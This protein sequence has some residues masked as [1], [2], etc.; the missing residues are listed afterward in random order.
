MSRDGGREGATPSAEG[1]AATSG[2]HEARGRAE[3][4][5]AEPR[6]G[7]GE[8]GGCAGEGTARR[9]RRSR[10]PSPWRGGPGWWERVFF[11]G[12]E[13]GPTG[14][15]TCRQFA[16]YSDAGVDLLKALSSLERQFRA[17]RARAGDGPGLAGGPTRRCAGRGH[18]APS[19]ARSNPLFLSMIKV[20]E[21]RGGVP[22]DLADALAAITRPARA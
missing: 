12:G 3:H 8:G 11:G 17:D 20:A 19:R 4:M 1:R 13:R 9:R 16:A 21:A 2:G 15:S 14:R 7:E 5:A 6:K 22:R 10:S 18:G